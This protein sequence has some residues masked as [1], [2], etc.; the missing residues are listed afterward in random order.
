MKDN[1]DALAVIVILGLFAWLLLLSGISS[2]YGHYGML[3][4]L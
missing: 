1:V 4:F 3:K 2:Y